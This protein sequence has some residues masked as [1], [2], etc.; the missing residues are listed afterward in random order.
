MPEACLN[1]KCGL[2]RENVEHASKLI[3]EGTAVLK[4]SVYPWGAEFDVVQ[5][6]NAEKRQGDDSKDGP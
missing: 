4:I 1:M 6:A 5:K 3:G 2:A